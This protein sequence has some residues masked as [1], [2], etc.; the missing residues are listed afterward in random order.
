MQICERIEKSYNSSLLELEQ[1]ERTVQAQW[2]TLKALYDSVNSKLC[3]YS[4]PKL[5]LEEPRL[6]EEVSQVKLEE[7]ETPAPPASCAVLNELVPGYQTTKFIIKNY[8]ELRRQK[9]VVYTEPF[10]SKNIEWRLKIYPNGSENS[11]DVYISIFVELYKLNGATVQSQQSVGKYKYRV[12]IINQLNAGLKFSRE[13]ESEFELGECWG[14]N[15]Y[16]KINM[17]YEEGYV[18][19]VEDHLEVILH[20]KSPSYYHEVLDLDRIL[21][22]KKARFDSN[23]RRVQQLKSQLNMDFETDKSIPELQLLTNLES[24]GEV[25]SLDDI[26]EVSGT[27]MEIDDS[28]RVEDQEIFGAVLQNPD[29]NSASNTT[30]SALPTPRKELLSTVK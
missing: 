20:I 30:A 24:E 1:K 4:K 23:R 25:I 8:T 10:P 15:T 27:H 26:R 28:P 22:L 29:A 7:L 3:H 11:E 12:D 18:H 5:I 6:I 13:F 17:L 2:E 19:P 9:E 21:E 16:A 14:Y